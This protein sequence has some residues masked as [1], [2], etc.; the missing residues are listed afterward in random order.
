MNYIQNLYDM[1]KEGKLPKIPHIVQGG[2]LY[3]NLA[4][5]VEIWSKNYYSNEDDPAII[6]ITQIREFLSAQ[7]GFIA[8]SVIKRISGKVY[9]CMVFSYNKAPKMLLEVLNAEYVDKQ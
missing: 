7:K 2:L 1:K 9:R 4:S 6:R 8:S 3:F 5:F